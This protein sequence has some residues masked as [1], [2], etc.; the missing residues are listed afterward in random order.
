MAIGISFLGTGNYQKVTYIF[1]GEKFETEYFPI[2][3]CHFLKLDSLYLIMTEESRQKHFEEFDQKFKDCLVNC[4]LKKILIPSGKTEDELWNIFE[5]IASN[6]PENSEISFDITHAFRSIPFMIFAICRYL[7]VVKKVTIK[8]IVYGAFEARLDNIAP[9]FNLTPFLDLIQMSDAVNHFYLFGNSSLIA[10]ILNKIQGQFYMSNVKSI[11]PTKLKSFGDVLDNLTSAL[12]I[13]RIEEAI[14]LS[15]ELSKKLEEF[16]NEAKELP[17]AKPFALLLDKIQKRFPKTAPAG[18][19]LFSTE[20]FKIQANLL[21]FYIETNQFVQAITL[22]R[23]IIVSFCVVRK[24][25]DP[26][27][28]ACRE[29]VE[30]ELGTLLSRLKN[31]ENLSDQERPLAEIWSHITTTRNDI[32]HAGMNEH[33]EKTSTAIDNVKDICK[34]VT[35]FICSSH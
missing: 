2:A 14:K 4:T 22:A 27:K 10:E 23:E 6:L 32:D 17:I 11:K 7:S 24:N 21:D 15:F 3:F 26:K 35:E 33:P 31:K 19:Y 20:G 8:N 12:S 16:S 29:E 28:K 5:I 1:N 9:V 18:F 34:M 25:K 30:K 13:I